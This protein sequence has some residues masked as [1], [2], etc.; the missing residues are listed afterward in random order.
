MRATII[1][2]ERLHNTQDQ[3]SHSRASQPQ[4]LSGLVILTGTWERFLWSHPLDSKEAGD[5]EDERHKPVRKT[6]QAY[7]IISH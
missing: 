7:R 1:L 2:D 5:E 4:K 6:I 3:T